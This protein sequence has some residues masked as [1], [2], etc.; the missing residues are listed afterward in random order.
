ME[1]TKENN[2]SIISVRERPEYRES[3]IEYISSKWEL[4]NPIIYENSISHCINSPNPLPQW[5]LLKKDSEIIGCAG[6]ITNDFI[7]RMDLYPWLCALFIEENYRGNNYSSLL[8]E[9][10]KDDAIKGGFRNLYLCTDH[11]GLY[12]KHGFKYIGQ[13]YHP[14]EE[15]SR[16]YGINLAN[17]VDFTIR[18]ETDRDQA[19]I[20]TL[21]KTAFETAKVKDG[22]EQD[23]A[24]NLRKSDRY[25]PE[26]ALVAQSG[27]KLI[28]HIMLTK[29]KLT[30][31]D[32]KVEEVL[33][34]APLSVLIEYRD[35]GVGSALMK[36]GLRKAK[37]MGYNAAFLCGDP[38]YYER[39]GYKR[40]SLFGIGNAQNIPEQYVLAYE[41]KRNALEEITGTVECC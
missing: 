22:N 37:E 10:A 28:G 24:A 17:K 39:F 12:E 4:V 35:K 38:G 8:L 9:K 6:L 14:W 20:Y 33:L 11:I 32:G 3:A 30:R 13:G 41:L 16:I 21:I 25:I 40:S 23:F 36:E 7:S 2:I 26:L 29:T 27:G 34:V 1:T 15:S 19:E 31:P 5:Y 18:E